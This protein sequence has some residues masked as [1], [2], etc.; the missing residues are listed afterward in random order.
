VAT[1]TGKLMKKYGIPV[2]MLKLKGAF[3]TN[4]KVCLDERKGRVDAEL[5]RLFAPEDLSA[6]TPEEIENKMN[7]ALWQDEYEWNAKEKIVYDSKGNICSHLNDLCYRCPRCGAELQMKA[8]KNDIH[9]E[10]C[11]NGAT[12]DDTYT[13][14]PYDDKCVIPVSPSRW[15]DE[16]RRVVAKEI[17]ENP[18][19]EFVEK[20]KLGKLPEY[21]T[22]KHKGTSVLCGEGIIRINH[23]GFHYEGTKDGQPFHFDLSP[24]ELPTL[25]MVTDVS[26][27]ALYANAE[28]YDLFPERPCVGKI[29]LIVEE[30][31]RL[32]V[33]VWKNFPWMDWIY[34]GLN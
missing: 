19:F 22:I 33:N 12:M 29:L 20:V 5:S 18:N 1:G 31:H 14:H 23:Q 6:L 11:G 8:E 4:T 34:E 3:L 24:G 21:K 2:Y 10:A 15:V 26:F 7:E 25:G 9:C 16:E 28:Y 32:H 27:F 13:F 30:M 17:R